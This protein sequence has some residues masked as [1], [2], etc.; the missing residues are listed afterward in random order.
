MSRIE[1]TFKDKQ[2]ILNIYVTA[3]FPNLNDTIEIIQELANNGVDM[4][5]IGMPFSDPFA[6]WTNHTK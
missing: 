5:E 4:I 1:K 2:N 3:G 6:D